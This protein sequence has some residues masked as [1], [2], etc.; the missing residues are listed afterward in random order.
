[1]SDWESKTT[2]ATDGLFIFRTKAGNLFF[3]ENELN[4]EEK[5]AVERH[6]EAI[7]E[8]FRRK[9]GIVPLAGV[10][11]QK[12]GNSGV[13]TRGAFSHCPKCGK[14]WTDYRDAEKCC[15]K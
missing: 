2:Y 7:I 3:S 13:W 11:G 4:P 8:T 6:Q 12:A 14:G 10:I 15:G 1:M 9:P 5:D